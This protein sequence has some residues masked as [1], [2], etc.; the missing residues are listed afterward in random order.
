M[1]GRIFG[2]ALAALAAAPLNAVPAARSTTVA[3]TSDGQRVI[4]ANRDSGSV[5]VIDAARRVILAEVAVCNEPETVAAAERVYVACADGTL[6]ALALNPPRVIAQRN[7]GLPLFGVVAGA[8]RLFVTSPSAGVLLSLDPESLATQKTLS[9][10][11]QPRGL[12]VDGERL[13]VTH[14]STGALT[15]IHPASL[16]VAAIVETGLDHNLAQSVWISDGRAWLPQTRSN[17]ANPALLFDTTVFPVVAVVNLETQQNLQRERISIDTAD[18]PVNMPLDAVTTAG[19]IYIVNAGSDD[20]S[21]IDLVRRIATAHL[22]VGSNPRGIALSL[23]GRFAYVNNALSGTLSVIDTSL[24]QVIDEIR[25]TNIALP[26]DVLNGK[27][28]FHTSN[29]TA[30]AKDRWIS[31]AT[32]HFDGGADGRTWFFRDGPRNTTALFGLG[33]TLPM[34]WSGDLDELQDVE[35]TIRNIQAGSGLAPGASNC[36]PACDHAP[37]NAGRSA[38]LDDLAAFMRALR[39]PRHPGYD[40]A[41]A[42]RGAVHFFDSRTRCASCH[43]PPLYTDRTRHDVGTGRS[44]GERKGTSFDTPSLRGIYATPPYF[45]DGSAA[46]LA[47]VVNGATGVHGDTRPLTPEQRNDLVEFLRSLD[48]DVPRRRA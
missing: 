15:A 14:F 27:R 1:R 21:V 23:D 22:S 41:A 30:L 43:I 47:D 40:R 37:P 33:E 28:L 38:D 24:D 32:C 44:P 25:L 31:C 48:F 4:A 17:T 35:S 39:A 18:R 12:A 36:E 42:S 6:A 13:Y 19:K 8:S 20:V 5:T 46:S 3:V 2:A 7:L 10:P 16:T 11:P 26:R 29:S 9:L 45:H 34:H